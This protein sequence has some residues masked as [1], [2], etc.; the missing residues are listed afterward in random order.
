MNVIDI[1]FTLRLLLFKPSE[2]LIALFDSIFCKYQK[3]MVYWY[4]LVLPKSKE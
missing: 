2:G 1:K 4:V 3:T